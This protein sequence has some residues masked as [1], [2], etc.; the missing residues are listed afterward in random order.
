MMPL[1]PTYVFVKIKSSMDYNTALSVTGVYSF[2]KFGTD[3]A[4]LTD[5]EYNHIKVLTGIEEINSIEVDNS[6]IRPG[7]VRKISAG[8]LKGLECQVLKTTNSNKIIV[9]IDSLRQNIIASL[10]KCCLEDTIGSYKNFW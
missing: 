4:K 9:R 10:P 1:L 5:Q 7:E 2:I 3:F 6:H 8:L